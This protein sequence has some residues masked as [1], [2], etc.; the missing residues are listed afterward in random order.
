MNLSRLPTLA[1]LLVGSALAFAPHLHAGASNKSGSPFGNGTFFSDSGNFSA[2]LRGENAFLGVCQF[3]TSATNNN[4]TNSGFA[5]IYAGGNQYLGSV[6]G[7]INSSAQTITVNYFGNSPTAVTILPSL[8]ADV[9]INTAGVA[10]FAYTSSTTNF[11]ASNNC[12]GQF[13]AS[14]KNSYPLQTF[15]GSGQATVRSTTITATLVPQA[16]N[17]SAYYNYNPITQTQLIDN[18]V[19]GSRLTQ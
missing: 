1:I 7:T 6:I 19:S 18:T 9:N 11:V 8:T 4:A 13:T 3:T 2:V 17:Q 10:S 12:V 15:F 5:S 14:L 16:A